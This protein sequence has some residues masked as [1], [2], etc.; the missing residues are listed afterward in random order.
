MRNVS[1]TNL[2]VS[3]WC[4]TISSSHH[5][6][7]RD[8]NGISELPLIHLSPYKIICIIVSL[9]IQLQS[10]GLSSREERSG[11]NNPVQVYR[12]VKSGKLVLRPLA[13]E[14]FRLQTCDGLTCGQMRTECRPEM[15]FIILM[16]RQKN[17]NFMF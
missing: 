3:G 14:F 11:D 5:H 15:T 17:N 16:S 8:N 1:S 13:L 4:W 12:K 6:H 9:E 2:R 7:T 10:L